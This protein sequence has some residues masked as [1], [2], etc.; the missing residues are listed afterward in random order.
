M[1]YHQYSWFNRHASFA[2]YGN[3]ANQQER[4]ES[5]FDSHRKRRELTEIACDAF[6]KAY[7]P[8]QFVGLDEATRAHKHQGKQRIRFKAA[9]H[10]GNLVDSLNDCESKYCLWFEEQ[11]W[12]RREEGQPDPNTLKA[13]LLRA[14][15]CL[16]DDG[17]HVS[18]YA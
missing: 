6:A 11:Q 4:G 14:G 7:R 5:G 10:S 1:T 13:R 3:A 9:V 8:R 16:L 15:K 18:M 17:A 2:D 12:L